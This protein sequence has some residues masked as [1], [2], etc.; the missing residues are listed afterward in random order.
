ME[1]M[2]RL[3]IREIESRKAISGIS[4]EEY[5]DRDLK[6]RRWKEITNIMC[7]DNE[8]EKNEF[9]FICLFNF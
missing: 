8:N 2:P 1:Y 9:D 6:R 7:E 5:S 3:L 4:F